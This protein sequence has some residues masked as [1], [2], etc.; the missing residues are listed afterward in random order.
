MATMDFDL[1]AIPREFPQFGKSVWN[2]GRTREEVFGGKGSKCSTAGAGSGK[3][4]DAG[5]GCSGCGCEGG[6]CGC[7]SSGGC[8]STGGRH[9]QDAEGDPFGLGDPQVP[10]GPV[11]AAR[12]EWGPRARGGLIRR[13]EGGE[14]PCPNDCRFMTAEISRCCR[15]AS[16][17]ESA[18]EYAR[19]S[20]DCFRQQLDYLK[21]C[22]LPY[23]TCPDPDCRL[24][25]YPPSKRL[26]HEK[27]CEQAVAACP[28]C[29]LNCQLMLQYCECASQSHDP[30]DIYW[31]NQ[32]A[33][34]LANCCDSASPR[35]NKLKECFRS[36]DDGYLFC[37]AQAQLGWFGGPI[38][39]LAANAYCFAQLL[40]CQMLCMSRY[41]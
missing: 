19:V 6:S 5:C 22:K 25:H 38:A 4:T 20:I 35:R 12:R 3:C 2:L 24:C 36:C 13:I 26:E 28:W 37:M 27:M 39:G 41:P 9:A 29:K 14:E 8:G 1:A 21:S 17:S 34:N 18:T 16:E 40:A 31:C 10:V 33:R 23:P 32:N 7:S 15:E 11:Y 30:N